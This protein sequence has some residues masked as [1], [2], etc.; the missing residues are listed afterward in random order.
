MQAFEARPPLAGHQPVLGREVVELFLPVLAA[1]E[2]PLVVDATV[3]LGGHA[4]LILE[5]VPQARLLG[6]DRDPQAL[7]VARERLSPWGSRV[8][9]VHR[10]FAHLEDI[11]KEVG[12]G[13]PQALLAD[14]GVSSPQLDT[15]ERGFSFRH[16]GPLDMRMDPTQGETAAQ[17]LARL[18]ERQLVEILTR[19]G[20][21]RHAQRIA[22]HLVRLRQRVPLTTTRALREAVVAAL[23]PRARGGLDHPA[24]RT[25]QA[26]RI[27][28][29]DELGALSSLLDAARRVLSP[30]GRMAVVAFHS[31]EDRLVKHAFRDWVAQGDAVLLTRR[32]IRPGAK[33]RQ[34]NPRSRSA[35]LRAV[36]RLGGAERFV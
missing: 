25:F 5:A 4:S 17:L 10:N 6:L 24:R 18:S 7:E 11:L 29:N 12:W 32:P 2:D 34:D 23:P 8:C 30:G 22:R 19:Y 13:L 9:L 33:E 14:L 36:E 21:E 16:D 15:G 35:R 1:G 20:E 28:V 26:L 3:G 27:A 31:L